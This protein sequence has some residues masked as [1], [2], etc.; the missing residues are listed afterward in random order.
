MARITDPEKLNRI[1]NSTMELLVRNGYSGIT[2]AAIA[3]EARVSVG[4]LY[5]H[6]RGKNE[7]IN[8]LVLENFDYLQQ[9]VNL[10]LDQ[11]DD[12]ATVVRFYMGALF[13]IANEAPTKARFIGILFRDPHF[14]M[15]AQGKNIL[16]I[17]LIAERIL[18]KGQQTHEIDPKVSISEIMLFLLN[19]PIDFMTQ[20]LG[21]DGSSAPFTEEEITRIAGMCMRAL[22]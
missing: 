1:K 5:R 19:I 4:Y 13:E 16:N 10:L 3:F 18:L 2:I 11:S 22:A 12:V 9:T 14:R 6:F 21:A 7:L 8:Y 17:P 15:E 20:R